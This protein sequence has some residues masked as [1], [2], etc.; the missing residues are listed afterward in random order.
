MGMKQYLSEVQDAAIAAYPVILVM[1]STFTIKYKKIFSNKK[2]D[3]FSL[4]Q[5]A[6]VGEVYTC[7]APP[8][9]NVR[10]LLFAY[11]SIYYSFYNHWAL[12]L[13]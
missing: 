12:M 13:W 6:M 7:P 4:L 2:E 5:A 1:A 10:Y 3:T 11:F 8:Y 9:L